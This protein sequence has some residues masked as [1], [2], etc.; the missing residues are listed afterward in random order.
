VADI[1]HAQPG[2]AWS[3]ILDTPEPVEDVDLRKRTVPVDFG[4]VGVFARSDGKEARKTYHVDLTFKEMVEGIY[5]GKGPRMELEGKEYDVEDLVAEAP[6]KYLELQDQYDHSQ[7]DPYPWDAI[8]RAHVLR[9]VKGW[10]HEKALHTYLKK[11]PFLVAD[12]G[13]DSI[14]NQSTLWRAWEDRF[15]DEVKEAIR[16]TAEIAVEHARKHDAPAPD[17]DFLPEMDIDDDDDETA[18]ALARDKARQVWRQAKPFV[19]DCFEL[20]RA[21][22][23]SIPEGAWWEQHAYMGMRSDMYANAGAQSFAEDTT[24]EKT[25]SGDSHRYQLKDLDIEDVRRMLRESTRAMTARARSQKQLGGQLVAIDITKGFEWTGQ[26][27][28]NTDGELKEPCILGYKNAALYFQWAVIKI[29]GD[30]IPFILDAVPVIRGRTRA[31]IV[32]DLLEGALSIVPEI[33]MVMMDREFDSE[34]VKE[35]CEDHDVYYLNPSRVF[36]RDEH[37]EHIA[38][39]EE[40]GKEIDVVEQ[41]RLDGGE[42][43]KAM[44]LPKREYEVDDD[45]EESEQVD[46]NNVR[47]E[48]IDDLGLEESDMGGEDDK[49]RD[50]FSSLLRDIEDEVDVPEREEFEVLT[51]PFETNHPLIDTDPADDREMAH[52][53]GRMMSRYKRRWGIENGFKKIKKFLCRT[54]SKDH[55]Y[56]YFNFA[57]ACVLYNCWRVVDLL[58]QLSMRDTFSYQPEIDANLFLT[59]SKQYFGLDPP[60]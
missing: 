27:M 55:Q 59:I 4:P 14:P 48:M 5:T 44:Y 21:D 29:V 46:E 1:K 11:R 53:V 12:L 28:R 35:A 3:H 34:G 57:F 9:L 32:D 15:T 18:E 58:V 7:G 47:Q 41:E 54:T 51:V 52:Q 13:F 22:N 26:V 56:R 31:D 49:E 25:P 2:S 6:A 43:R 24:R 60:E 36:K 37:A 17:P 40:E 50:S 19:T 10:K 33:E 23:A 39:M 45:D 38:K 16:I 42:S 20:D 30:D 8:F